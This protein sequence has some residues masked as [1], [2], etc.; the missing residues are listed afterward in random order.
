[1]KAYKKVALWMSMVLTAALCNPCNQI[2]VYGAENG[3][4]AE[5]FAVEE[6][7]DE[8]DP[9][10]ELSGNSDSDTEFPDEMISE[11][12]DM[13]ETA[14]AETD[15]HDDIETDAAADAGGTE[16]EV[17]VEETVS[18][19]EETSAAAPAEG[20]AAAVP[21]DGSATGAKET[22]GDLSVLPIEEPAL[23]EADGSIPAN[24]Y[25]TPLE[26]D[27]YLAEEFGFGDVRKVE[28]T[29]PDGYVLLRFV[30]E[31]TT[32]YVFYSSNASG[33]PMVIMFD[34]DCRLRWRT[35]A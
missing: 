29:K 3:A 20:S 34:S 1:M 13:A 35:T 25:F 16:A 19:D 12:S 21:A 15:T 32:G 26:R 23:E 9:E 24:S 17:S 31:E 11:K 2:M 14:P 6:V 5:G 10:T 27:F 8:V 30:P 18:D 4:V 33:I 7:I 22:A 28:I